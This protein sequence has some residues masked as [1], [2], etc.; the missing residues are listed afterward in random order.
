[1]TSLQPN[2]RDHEELDRDHSVAR[3]TQLQIQ[4]L[5]EVVWSCPDRQ[6]VLSILHDWL[7]FTADGFEGLAHAHSVSYPVFRGAISLLCG[8]SVTAKEM[9]SGKTTDGLDLIQLVVAGWTRERNR[10]QEQLGLS[11]TDQQPQPHT[12]IAD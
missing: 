7:P 8:R 3:K 2:H 9:N 10:R 4:A 5:A 1:M 12:G 6:R 11:I